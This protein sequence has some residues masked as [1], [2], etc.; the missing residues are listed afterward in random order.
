M[1]VFLNRSPSR[2]SLKWRLFGSMLLLTAILMFALT[3]G[4]F[5]CGRFSST[6][7]QTAQTLSLQME[8]FERDMASYWEKTTVLGIHLSREITGLTE[9]Y[10]AEQGI[11]FGQLTDSSLHIAG[12]QAAVIDTLCQS[13]RQ[14]DCSGAF[15]LF[16]TTVNSRIADSETSRSGL[17]IQ[18]SG[19]TIA[20]DLLLYR[21]M[22]EVG[23]SC[24]MP[25]HRKWR[26]EFQ[27]SLFP[28]YQELF[29]QAAL[30]L[31]TS[32]R[33]TDLFT[34]P[35]TS[36]QAVLLTVP[37]IGSDG[38]V[39]GLCGFEISQQ[40]FKLLH[41]QPTNM[42]H[43]V[44]LLAT[45]EN[46][47]LDAENGLSCG[48]S[49]GYYFA[50]KGALTARDLGGG[51]TL[52]S[53]DDASYIG[54]SREI[55]I[56]H[57][58]QTITAA[59][60]IPQEDYGRALLKSNMQTA[61][62]VLLLLFFSL[63]CCLYFSR[64]FISPILKSLDKIKSESRI[65]EVSAIAEI[66]D[67]F[68]FLAQQ[69]REHERDLAALVQEKQDAQ[70]EKERLQEALDRAQEK[71]ESAQTEISRLAYSRKQEVDPADYQRFLQGVDTLT[72][73]ERKIFA[74]YLSGKTV[75]EILAVASIK[76]STLRYHNK[77]IY[78]KLGVNSLKQLLRYAALMQRDDKGEDSAE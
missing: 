30:P 20:D 78:S 63:V 3:S 11:S 43:M 56:S 66:N 57:R 73:A 58:D 8:V 41:G 77:N 1:G 25:P 69:D 61:L 31:E 47:I 28:N 36:E 32:Y 42:P 50:P 15:A 40:Y 27:S 38:A 23:K 14:S 74:Y 4:L 62:L 53:G 33:V 10:L 76:E 12:V 49:N 26:L 16:N 35:G 68:D 21:G 67:L 54:V 37:L 29:S 22:T 75:K 19:N 39:Y 18:K 44:C 17:Y 71:Y 46:G 7:K 2:W 65:G 59:V 45:C 70:N 52:F 48:V 24:G 60:L 55:F 51:L 64:R 9:D 13:L 72:P 34:I 5:L 6:K